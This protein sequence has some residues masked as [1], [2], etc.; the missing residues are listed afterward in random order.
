MLGEARTH[1]ELCGSQCGN[2]DPRLKS[3]Y[4]ASFFFFWKDRVPEGAAPSYHQTLSEAS[5]VLRTHWGH[6]G[7]LTGGR[8]CGQHNLGLTGPLLNLGQAQGPLATSCA[9]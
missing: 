8:N 7:L 4:A 1:A 5:C 2:H 9:K 3:G 6:P